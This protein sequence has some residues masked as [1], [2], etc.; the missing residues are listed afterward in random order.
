MNQVLVVLPLLI[1]VALLSGLVRLAARFTGRISVS[2]KHAVVYAVVTVLANAAL[3]MAV[4]ASG[5]PRPA[6]VFPVL[7]LLVQ[8]VLGALYFAQRAKT[9][10]GES[11]GAGRGA[12]I[13]GIVFAI[14]TAIA[15][16]FFALAPV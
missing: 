3:R 5:V 14:N 8:L 2:W 1:A 11:I 7:S 12:K 6:I 9:V 13:S 10:D 4:V 16:V 15:G